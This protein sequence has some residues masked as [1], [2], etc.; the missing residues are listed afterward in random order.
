LGVDIYNLSKFQ[1][2]NHNT[3][4]NQTPLVSVGNFVKKGDVISDGPSA[5]KG[6][7]AL[8]KNVLIAFV[9]WGGYN[10]EDAILISE[11]IVRDDVY[12]SIHIEEFE[13]VLRDTRLGPEE[14]TRDIPNVS[15]EAIR[16]LDEAGIIYAGAQIKPGD[17]L[18][19][20]I[21]PKSETPVTSEEKLLR[22][23]FGEK[24]ADVKDSSLYAPPGV[25]GTV[26]EVRIFARRGVDKDQRSIAI[27]RQQ[28]E[29]LY[30]IK[31][32]ELLVIENFLKDKITSLLCNNESSSS[33]KF[34]HPGI[35]LDLN[36][37][38]CVTMF[39]NAF[40]MLI[41]RC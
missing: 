40:T 30:K 23:I 4:I 41:K 35:K 20:K 39:Y 38:R 14:I 26:I 22:A 21:T 33:N 17:V 31:M 1:K 29:K 25:N 19:G 28:I 32:Q 6:E 8:G 16:N 24:A 7:I 3:C 9:P 27:E 5:D 15:D 37:L 13:I 12:T 36:V 2:S 10:F 18:V 34:V 11:R